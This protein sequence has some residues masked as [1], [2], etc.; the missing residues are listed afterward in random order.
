MTGPRVRAPALGVS[1]TNTGVVLTV[2]GGS[3]PTGRGYRERSTTVVGK[4]GRDGCKRN[5]TEY[6]AGPTF[7]VTG[8]FLFTP[9][10]LGPG[11]S[12]YDHE[13]SFVDDVPPPSDWDPPTPP[14]RRVS[15]AVCLTMAFLFTLRTPSTK[16]KRKSEEFMTK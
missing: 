14:T 16:P 5:V 3:D 6:L 7:P 9:L 4:K 15:S 12:T 8:L 1:G 13:T 2:V 11:S 10:L